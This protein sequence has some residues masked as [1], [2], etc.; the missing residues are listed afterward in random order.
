[1]IAGGVPSGLSTGDKKAT[2]DANA[3][4]LVA[5]MQQHLVGLARFS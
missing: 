2:D 4:K 5:A 3:Q 1:M